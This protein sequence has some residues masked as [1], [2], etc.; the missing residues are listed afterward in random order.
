FEGEFVDF[1]AAGRAIL[2]GQYAGGKKEGKFTAYHPN[3][4]VKWTV[5]F[6]N[7]VPSGPWLLYYP[8]GKPLLE[9]EYGATGTAIRNFWDARGRQR[10]TDGNG[11]YDFEIPADGYNPYGYVRY[12]RRGRVVDGRPHGN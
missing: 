5:S 4:Q 9:V 3:G 10:V 8:D 6:R 2:R 12:R 1:N 11:R 7:D